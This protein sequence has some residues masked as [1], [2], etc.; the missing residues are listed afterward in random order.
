MIKADDVKANLMDEFFEADAQIQECCKV[1]DSLVQQI[2]KLN[3]LLRQREETIKYW[4][5]RL[6]DLRDE[7]AAVRKKEK[8]ESNTS[9]EAAPAEQQD[10]PLPPSNG[11][12][13]R[14]SKEQ[15]YD[16]K[17]AGDL[18]MEVLDVHGSLPTEDIV[19]MLPFINESTL[20]KKLTNLRWDGKV[21]KTIAPKDYHKKDA[22][23][24]RPYL[25]ALVAGAKKKEQIP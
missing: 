21:Q 22:L 23:G 2:E 3:E 24:R 15:L 18:I 7:I 11:K 20:R 12:K 8:Q 25:W 17:P 6:G 5:G 10:L 13:K 19:P 14:K 4:T 16:G 1:R 9:A